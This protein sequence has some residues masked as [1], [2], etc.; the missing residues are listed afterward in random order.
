MVSKKA[1]NIIHKLE[2]NGQIYNAGKELK[3]LQ[4]QLPDENRP[5]LR[6]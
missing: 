3:N 1:T 2:S 6:F 4:M 5:S